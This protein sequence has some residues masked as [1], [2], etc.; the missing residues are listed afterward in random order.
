MSLAVTG[1]WYGDGMADPGTITNGSR[2]RLFRQMVGA[3]RLPS[4]VHRCILDA[5]DRLDTAQPLSSSAA[6]KGNVTIKWLSVETGRVL[7]GVGERDWRRYAPRTIPSGSYV[8]GCLTVVVWPG[9][10]EK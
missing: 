8:A 2:Q 4:Q 6:T 10:N 3:F 5:A 1:D 9:Y 7:D